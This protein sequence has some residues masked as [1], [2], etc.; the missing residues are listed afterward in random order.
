MKLCSVCINS[1]ILCS[2]CGRKAADGRITQADM[3]VSRALGRVAEKSGIDFL[4]AVAHGNQIIVVCE[5]K[6][7][8]LIIGRGGKNAKAASKILGKVMR[9]IE[10]SGEKKMIEDILGVPV[11]GI[12]VVYGKA[13]VRR[14]RLN[15]AFRRL[16]GDAAL[17][18]KIFRR[19]YEIA[20][21]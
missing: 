7:A 19:K 17:L 21:E 8:R 6:D 13:E 4:Q 9:I 1:D 10:N 3:D 20:F 15:R 11:I 16:R 12:N 2:G 18:E 5:K 14:I